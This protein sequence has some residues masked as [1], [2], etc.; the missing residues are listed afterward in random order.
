VRKLKPTAHQ[1]ITGQFIVYN[2]GDF[3]VVHEQN[4]QKVTWTDFLWNR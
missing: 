2:C 1:Y 3:V 4:T